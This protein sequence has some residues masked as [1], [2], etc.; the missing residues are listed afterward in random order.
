VV[1]QS[2]HEAAAA[3]LIKH[4]VVLI[5]TS[6]TK[7]TWLDGVVLR[8]HEDGKFDVGVADPDNSEKSFVYY[9]VNPIQLRRPACHFARQPEW[10]AHAARATGYDQSEVGVFLF[11][12]I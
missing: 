3:P 8:L 1:V 10:V 11:F 6:K 4:D 5:C 2:F 9:S 7:N 12:V